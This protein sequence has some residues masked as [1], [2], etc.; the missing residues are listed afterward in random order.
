MGYAPAGL[1]EGAREKLHT[2]PRA[3]A[4]EPGC[5][6]GTKTVWLGRWSKVG[7]KS[8]DPITCWHAISRRRRVRRETLL[9]GGLIPRRRRRAPSWPRSGRRLLRPSPA[10]AHRRG[11]EETCVTHWVGGWTC[12]V[13]LDPLLNLERGSLRGAS[14]NFLGAGYGCHQTL[15]EEMRMRPRA[16][17]VPG[18]GR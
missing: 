5:G 18:G 7:T 1:P 14:V 9:H 8:L 11:K 16:R 4:E 6:S 15:L 13:W 2:G 12:Y 17:G 10:G 3:R